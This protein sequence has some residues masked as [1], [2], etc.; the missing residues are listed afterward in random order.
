MNFLSHFYFDRYNSTSEKVIGIV[1]PD[2]VK[3][4]KKEWALHPEKNRDLFIFDTYLADI[5]DGWNRHLAV[6]KYF[7]CSDFFLEHTQNLRQQIVPILENSPVRPSFVA[8]IALEL[9]LDSLLITEENINPSDFYSHLNKV[10]RASLNQFLILNNINDTS[11]F[12]N[13][14]DEFIKIAYLNQYTE[15]STLV[16]SINRICMRIWNMPFD[17]IL[18]LKLTAVLISYQEK[19]KEEFIYIFDYIDGKLK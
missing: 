15:A 18:K 19:L 2:L 8:H 12:F 3:N 10:K 16:Y 7:H 17:E 11:P 4:A 5:L 6:D 14:Y 13:F 1:L 9:M